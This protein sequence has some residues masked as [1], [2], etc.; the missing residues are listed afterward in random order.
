MGFLPGP[1][2]SHREVMAWELGRELMGEGLG[3][4]LQGPHLRA[5]GQELGC[6]ILGSG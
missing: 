3:G 1:S 4:R 5:L 6:K 2:Q